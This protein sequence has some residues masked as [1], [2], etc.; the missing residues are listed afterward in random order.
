MN[1]IPLDQL[2]FATFKELVKTQFLVEVAPA[3]TVELEL[4]E[5][6]FIRESGKG[7]SSRPK[8]E[9]FSLIFSGTAGD[10]LTQKTYRFMHEKIGSFD[11]FIVPIAAEGGTIRYQAVFNRLLTPT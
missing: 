6:D 11:L 3:K 5:A 4:I 7:E 2:S 10:R 9:D 8:Y 1:Q